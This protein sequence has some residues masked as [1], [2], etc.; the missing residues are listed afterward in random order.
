MLCLAAFHLMPQLRVSHAAG[1]GS[2][3]TIK[4]EERG[5]SG[6]EGGQGKAPKSCAC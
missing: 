6:K 1:I 4:A 3:T 2:T 5:E